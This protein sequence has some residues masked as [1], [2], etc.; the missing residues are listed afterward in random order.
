MNPWSLAAE[1]IGR[2]GFRRLK[3]PYGATEKELDRKVTSSKE[4]PPPDGAEGRWT[5]VKAKVLRLTGTLASLAALAAV[6]GA[7]CKWG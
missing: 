2:F 1:T 3:R 7:G 5:N 4:E 6:L